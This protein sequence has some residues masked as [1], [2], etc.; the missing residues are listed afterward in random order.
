MLMGA[1]FWDPD[2][3]TPSLVLLENKNSIKEVDI[4]NKL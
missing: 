4:R 2:N 1:R 3:C